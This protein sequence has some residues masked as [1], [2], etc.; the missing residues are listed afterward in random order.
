MFNKEQKI[1]SCND[2]IAAISTHIEMLSK[3]KVDSSAFVKVSSIAS[4]GIIPVV[5]TAVSV[6]GDVDANKLALYTILA[7]IGA[8]GTIFAGKIA[9]DTNNQSI[10][11]KISDDLREI[12]R[13]TNQISMIENAKSEEELKRYKRTM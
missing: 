5:S 7:S 2:K 11:F 1:E 12:D 9:I 8:A 6:L 10:N 13:L 4:C 3:S